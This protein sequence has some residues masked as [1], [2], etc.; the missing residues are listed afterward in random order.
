MSK[1]IKLNIK[2]VRI[3]PVVDRCSDTNYV[4]VIRDGSAQDIDLTGFTA[5]MQLR[6]Y[7]GAKKVYDELTTENGRLRIEGGRIFIN[8]PAHTPGKYIYDRAVYDL[9]V[10]SADGLQYRVAE[11]E[12]EVSREVTQ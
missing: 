4:F 2:P 9:Y 1:N 11:G 7:H 3:N 5:K 12:V 8:F 6:P 10:V